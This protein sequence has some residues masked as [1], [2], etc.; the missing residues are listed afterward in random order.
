LALVEANEF[1]LNKRLNWQTRLTLPRTTFTLAITG[2]E[3]ESLS[4]GYLDE[5]LSARLAMK[6]KFNS[7][8]DFDASFSY[9][10]NEFDK[11]DIS[12]GRQLDYYRLY[13][14]SYNRK[15]SPEFSAKFGLQFL[16]R[17]STEL[18]WQYEEGRVYFNLKKEF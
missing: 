4:S 17:N 5:Q 13:N 15:L 12:Q 11:E 9:R 14:L 16:N 18:Q 7:R 2:S 8:S 1:S 3:R 6:R 10:N